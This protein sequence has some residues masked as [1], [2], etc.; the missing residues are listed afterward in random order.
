MLCCIFQT[1]DKTDISAG[2]MKTNEKLSQNGI[3][4]ILFPDHRGMEQNEHCPLYVLSPFLRLSSNQ[5]EKKGYYYI[6]I[7]TT[8]QIKVQR[9]RGTNKKKNFTK[10]SSVFQSSLVSWGPMTP[11][12]EMGPPS[13]ASAPLIKLLV[14]TVSCC[15]W[16]FPKAT[17]CSDHCE[18]QQCICPHRAS[19]Q[20]AKKCPLLPDTQ[21]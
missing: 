5:Q 1:D 9:P 6:I 19:L 14:L 18:V 7:R 10:P 4:R 21:A 13:L 17:E 3:K 8:L 20:E 2:K 15:L 16:H 12:Q 11:K